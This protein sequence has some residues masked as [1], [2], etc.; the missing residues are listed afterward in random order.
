MQHTRKRSRAADIRPQAASSPQFTLTPLVTILPRAKKPHHN[1]PTKYQDITKLNK[2]QLDQS[3]LTKPGTAD[4]PHMSPPRLRARLQHIPETPSVE[5]PP[6]R[7]WYR[8]APPV[9]EGGAF[10]YM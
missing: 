6:E 4:P 8:R 1:L 7:T 9:A 2:I 3:R 10:G 5:Q